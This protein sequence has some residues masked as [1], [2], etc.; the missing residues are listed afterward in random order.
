MSITTEKTIREIALEQPATIRVF[1][2][3]GIDYCCGG[4][5]SIAQ[6]CSELQLSTDQVLEKL[7]EVSNSTDEND[8]RAW[9]SAPLAK[10]IQHIVRKHHTFCREEMPRLQALAEKVRSR[11]GVAHPELAQIEELFSAHRRELTTHML[12]EEQLLFPHIARVEHCAFAG[13]STP[14]AFFGSVANPVKAMLDEHDTAGDLLKQ[15]RKLS[16]DF[17][18]PMGACPSYQGLFHG[19]LAFERDLH[20]HVH[21][22]NNILFPRAIEMEGQETH[23]DQSDKSTSGS[24]TQTCQLFGVKR[25]PSC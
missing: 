17:T 9:Q 6:A 13:E 4:R 14:A 8:Q 15:I 18:P 22:E 19:L 25:S 7:Q 23:R 16:S 20:L 12:K 10:L 21:L 5:K 2:R 24:V 1:E 3:F 11:H